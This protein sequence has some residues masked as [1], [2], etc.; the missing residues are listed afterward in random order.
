MP[1]TAYINALRYYHFTAQQE[2]AAALCPL[3]QIEAPHYAGYRD[4]LQMPLQPL[5][6]HLE[7]A[8]Y[9]T[10]EHDKAKYLAYFH[11]LINELK[12]TATLLNTHVCGYQHEDYYPV[13]TVVGAGRGPLVGCVL[14]A[15]LFLG[16]G[17]IDR[18]KIFAVEKNPRYCLADYAYSPFLSLV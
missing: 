7:A 5:R 12:Y 8:T 6:D 3:D 10:F 9:E 18:V 1:G 17:L 13:V 16:G 15:C 2:A 11:A 14:D 4:R